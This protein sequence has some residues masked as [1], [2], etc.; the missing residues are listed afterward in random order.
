MSTKP[1]QYKIPETL[2]VKK[3]GEKYLIYN[4]NVPAWLVTNAVGAGILKLCDGT[5]TCDEIRRL[6]PSADMMTATKI[7]EFIKV[8]H[9]KQLFVATR[10]L[11]S[12]P[13]FPLRS[14]YLNI[15][16]VCN[17]RCS[18]CYAEE[19]VKT[20][21]RLTLKDYQRVVRE[22]RKLSAEPCFTFTGGEPLL[23]PLLIDVA[24]YAKKMGIRTFLLTNGTLITQKNVAQI[25]RVFDDV[26][27]SLDGSCASV[28][29][30]TRGAG[31]FDRVMEALRLLDI[32][33][34]PYRLSMTVTQKNIHDIGAMQ[35]RFGGILNYAPYFRRSEEGI[36]QELAISG[37]EYYQALVKVA[38]INPYCE[39][40]SVVAAN[41]CQRVI[42][43]CSIADGSISIAA[44]GDVFPCQLLHFAEFRAGNLFS[45]PLT[46]IYRKSPVLLKL[47]DLTVDNI[48]GCDK[49]P[50]S[51]I[52][53]GGCVARNFYETGKIDSAGEF[54]EYEQLAL[55]DALIDRYELE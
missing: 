12:A 11:H 5:H 4:P 19:R 45:A 23:S 7:E 25:A 36:N 32:V 21:K 39:I 28:N 9:E 13:H 48:I 17:L 10:I 3:K 29:D 47:R 52:C 1:E 2:L 34:K 40:D 26:K 43:K 54:C 31:V 44:N 51:Y 50:I 16:E 41:L 49:C 35:A 22:V 27:I 18:Y 6:L 14:I 42:Q 37:S 46:E 53:G 24:R 38:G 15:T 8:A 30:Q 55:F 33:G 20:E